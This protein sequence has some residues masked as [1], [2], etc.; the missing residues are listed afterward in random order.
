MT[1]SETMKYDAEITYCS[2]PTY[3]QSLEMNAKDRRKKNDDYYGGDDE[4]NDDMELEDVVQTDP[5]IKVLG[6]MGR[7]Q[8]GLYLITSLSIVIHA[9][10]MLV[11]KFLTYPT[12]YW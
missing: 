6:E 10:A 1:V 11:N 7:W 12:N 3:S 9:W 2:T 8:M 4:D 5:I